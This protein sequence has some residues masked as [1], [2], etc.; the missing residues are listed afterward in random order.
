MLRL[1]DLR[2]FFVKLL[3]ELLLQYKLFVEKLFMHKLLVQE[4]LALIS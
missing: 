3:L 4:V 1:P 2:Q